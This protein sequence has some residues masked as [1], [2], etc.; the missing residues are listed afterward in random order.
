MLQPL[1][2]KNRSDNSNYGHSTTDFFDVVFWKGALLMSFLDF[3]R[4]VSYA[5]A[6]A[7][8]FVNCIEVI[9]TRASNHETSLPWA[10]LKYE[11]WQKRWFTPLRAFSWLVH[12]RFSWSHLFHAMHRPKTATIYSP[13]TWSVMPKSSRIPMT[14]RS[15]NVG[16]R[17]LKVLAFCWMRCHW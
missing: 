3:I 16:F 17:G 2:T 13:F 15:Q 4:R 9:L 11:L 8:I 10:H 14:L 12:R 5:L 1:S 6:L 7:W